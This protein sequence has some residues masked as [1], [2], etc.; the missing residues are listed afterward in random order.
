M[1]NNLT[2]IRLENDDILFI[3]LETDGED[4]GGLPKLTDEKIQK[5]LAPVIRLGNNLKSSIQDLS[6]DEIE[7]SM[8]L[9]MS[10]ENDNYV[11]SV[12]KAAAEAQ[13]SVKFLWK[14]KE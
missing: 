6:P 12:V 10:L 13:I 7:L 14:K 4:W 3:D 11:F 2:Q 8:Q 1:S 5:A 9:S